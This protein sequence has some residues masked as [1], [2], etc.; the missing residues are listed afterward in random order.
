MGIF[1]GLLNAFGGGGGIGDLIKKGINI[2]S[3]IINRP[4]GMSIG[5]SLVKQLPNIA[6]GLG[7]LAKNFGGLIPGVGGIVS[8]I[9]GMVEDSAKQFGADKDDSPKVIEVSNSDIEE[10]SGVYADMPEDMWPTWYAKAQKEINA[11]RFKE[12]ISEPDMWAIIDRL[13]REVG[14]VNGENAEQEAARGGLNSH[15]SVMRHAANWMPV[16]VGGSLGTQMPTAYD[17][18]QTSHSNSNQSTWRNFTPKTMH[19]IYTDNMY[20]SNL[21]SVTMINSK[22]PQ[23]VEDILPRFKRSFLR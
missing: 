15:A 1:S 13:R 23:K 3:S 18:P 6:S 8:Q 22:K 14:G 5:D 12:H 16:M 19:D 9:G 2:G 21:P 11:R 7:G 17:A 4:E 10:P 20:A